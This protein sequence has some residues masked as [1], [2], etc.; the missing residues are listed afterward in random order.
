M[1]ANIVY[2]LWGVLAILWYR[3]VA[4]QDNPLVFHTRPKVLDFK[5]EEY[6][7]AVTQIHNSNTVDLGTK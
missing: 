3:H 7:A 2:F 6:V 1:E 5:D 4:T